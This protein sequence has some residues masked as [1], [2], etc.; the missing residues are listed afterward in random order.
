[1]ILIPAA[2]VIVRL[3]GV[4]RMLNSLRRPT[5]TRSTGEEALAGARGAARAVARASSR[6]PYAGNCLSR[7][8]AL[9]W[10]LRRHGVPA[11]LR[12]G[13]RTSEGKLLAH[14]WVET[15]GTVLNDS[16]AVDRRF[17]RFD[18]PSMTRGERPRT[19]IDGAAELLLA[20][21]HEDETRLN[22]SRLGRLSDAEWTALVSSAGC[23]R[24][25]PLLYRRL[26]AAGVRPHVPR[27][28]FDTL[29]DACRRI[30]FRNLRGTSEL[31]A[32]ARTLQ[33]AGI[34]VIVLKGAYLAPG[35]YGDPALREMNDLDIMVPKR[36]LPR[37]FATIQTCGYAP[38]APAT[39]VVRSEIRQDAPPLVKQGSMPIELHWTITPPL[40]P[41]AIEA[42]ELWTRTTRTTIGGVVIE[43]LSTEDLLLHL[44][45][46]ASYHHQFELGLRPFC[47]IARLVDVHHET[48]RWDLVV[49][50]VHRWQWSRGVFL[51]FDL[52][53]RLVG[54][55]IP[56]SVLESLRPTP[57]EP[58][59]VE[60][61]IAHTL[62]REKPG[63]LLS[64]H[65]VRVASREPL[66]VRGRHVLERIFLHRSELALEYPRLNRRL[67]FAGYALR[68]F[69]LARRYGRALARLLTAQPTPQARAAVRRDYLQQWMNATAQEISKSPGAR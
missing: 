5:R 14:A 15:Q 56:G 57:M 31:A 52:A 61:A 60:T 24:V 4:N 38:V 69:T 21:L 37:A 67:W 50:R 58:A 34:R 10:L 55:K 47:D 62:A 16:P 68:P 6:G 36:D 64:T 1:M 26:L 3:T 8:I 27:A 39:L 44:C 49:E 25:R 54:A 63:R 17:S 23:H 30:T 41:Y 13:A 35:V 20:C 18:A 9:M 46:H 11:D 2:A 43:A 19:V 42:D 65:V 29:G 48:L 22:V 28:V 66:S 33:D 51:A 32:V 59:I 53:V 12:F 45:A 40:E 7:S